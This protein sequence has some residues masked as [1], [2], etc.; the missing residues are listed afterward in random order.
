[1][2]PLNAR[3]IDVREIYDLVHCSSESRYL[4]W[5]MELVRAIS[6]YNYRRDRIVLSH[7]IADRIHCAYR[8]KV[9]RVIDELTWENDSRLGWDV[10][11]GQNLSE[12][13]I[14]AISSESGT[15]K[16]APRE[17]SNERDLPFHCS[18]TIGRKKIT[19]N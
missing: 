14:T 4:G 1:M 15:Q 11:A 17:G 16:T 12:R 19:R 9:S 6:A 10:G 7:E 5:F 3:T 13:L 8:W 18:H 2:L